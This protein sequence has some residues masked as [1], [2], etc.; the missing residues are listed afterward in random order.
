MARCESVLTLIYNYK[1]TFDQKE[2]WR[3][4]SGQRWYR[5]YLMNHLN[6]NG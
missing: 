3:R 2:V 1:T 4:V 5:V 6:K